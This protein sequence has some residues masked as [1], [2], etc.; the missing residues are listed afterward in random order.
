MQTSDFSATLE[1]FNSWF[2]VH[3]LPAFIIHT[4]VQLMQDAIDMLPDSVGLTARSGG[5][6]TINYLEV[7]LL[8][9]PVSA[10]GNMCH[11]GA[12]SGISR[13]PDPVSGVKVVD[14]IQYVG[15]RLTSNLQLESHRCR[16]AL[17]IG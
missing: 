11:K 16:W 7:D 14:N 4:F 10:I 3:I 2:I 12:D 6:R 5:R 15:S 9:F 1:K 17:I 8:A 13:F